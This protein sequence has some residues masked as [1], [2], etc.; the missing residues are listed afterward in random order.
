LIGTPQRKRDL[1]AEGKMGGNN[2][3]DLQRNGCED[4]TEMN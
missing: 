1:E 4:G 3:I 2:K